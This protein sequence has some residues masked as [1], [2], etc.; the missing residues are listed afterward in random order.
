MQRILEPE[1]MDDEEQAKCY[2]EADFGASNSRFMT[3]FK[4][5]FPEF[6]SGLILDLGC[7]PGDIPLRFVRRYSEV[8]VHGVDG[9]GPMLRYAQNALA[10]APD[11][12]FRVRFV[13]GTLPDAVLPWHQYDAIV[14]NSLLH[15]LHRPETLWS[16]LTELGRPGAI[17]CI[18]DLRRPRSEE[19]ARA[20]VEQYSG[21]EPE[22][23][24]RDF[25]NSLLAAFTV[26]EVREQLATAG[27]ELSVEACSDRHLLVWGYLPD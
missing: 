25:F 1:L 23:L 4:E 19:Q 10:H 5:R 3:L 7:G 8:T 2:A 22:L 11:L 18:M 20:I 27:L 14:S 26:D 21:D 16:T 24:K 15:H 17:V 6:S 13:Q 12:R 9:S